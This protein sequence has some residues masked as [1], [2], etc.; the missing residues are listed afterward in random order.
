MFGWIIPAPFATPPIRTVPAERCISRSVTLGRVSVVIIAR[1]VSSQPPSVSS[2][3][4]STAAM[5]STG[6]L[7]PMTPVLATATSYGVHSTTA[8]AASAIAIASRSPCS[9]VHAFALPELTTMARSGPRSTCRRV[10]RHGAAMTWLVVKTAGRGAR[11]L[12]HDERDVE[13][14]GTPVLH[15]G[16]RGAGAEAVRERDA[17]PLGHGQSGSASRPIVSG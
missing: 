4:G 7:K 14:L 16:L 2:M 9:P 8:A 5:R 10:T 12:R 15:A 1:E 11:P 6:S 17:A 3:P 13:A